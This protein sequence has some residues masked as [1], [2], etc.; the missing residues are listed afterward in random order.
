[1][2]KKVFRITD[3]SKPSEEP[4]VRIEKEDLM[5]L[6]YLKEEPELKP[7]IEKYKE[8]YDVTLDGYLAVGIPKEMDE[9][10]LVEKFLSGLKKLFSKNDNWTF[11]QPLALSIDFC[12]KCRVCVDAC[13]I[14]IS[15]G[16]KNIYEPP[17][18]A[19]VLRRLYRK[20]LTSS[21][22]VFGSFVAGEV[23]LNANLIKRLAELSYRCTICR[24]CSEVCPMGVDNGLITHELRKLFSQE[25]GIHAKE[26]HEKGTVQQLRVGSST[27]M[28]PDAFKNIVASMEEDIKDRTGLNIKIPVDEKGAD[29]LVI[30]NAGEF[31]S[32]PENPEAFA[33]IFEKAGLSWTL[34]SEKVGYD[35]VNYGVWYNDLQLT[36]LINHT[37]EIANKLDVKGI[38]IGECGHATKA[39]Y[40]VADR[41]VPKDKKIPVRSCL[42]VFDEIVSSGKLNLDPSRND[43]P[44]TLHDPCNTVRLSGIVEP[45][46]R[47]LRACT[48]DFREMTPN[49]EMNY[50]C[51]GGSG[52]A[53]MPSY[54]FNEWKMKVAGRMKVK[55]MLEVFS[56][57]L[58]KDVVKYVC[59][60]CSNCKGQ[61]R[62]LIRHYDLWKKYRIT[63][64]GLA[65]LIVNAMADIPRFLELD[66]H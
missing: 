37:F 43:F 61:L 31:L 3:L 17:F 46:R 35:A 16:R 5:P 55:Q 1:M 15:S 57:V 13:P 27:G 50:C 14:Y 19:E 33:I 29:Y 9:K 28:N 54:N 49:R 2:S 18:R 30:H 52:F 7:N 66:F 38:I 32:W 60:P 59:A 10:V 41:I 23:E 22:R 8:K 42:Q 20:Y 12:A 64:G 11:L 40:V 45:Q 4:I 21:G 65:D 48:K 56:D 36:K 44:V 63:Y 53:I 58:E 6:P 24:R 51:G 26:L 39:Y 25:L 47:V 62:D 34:S